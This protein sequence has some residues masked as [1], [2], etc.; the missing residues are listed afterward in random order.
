MG[1]LHKWPLYPLW[2][3]KAKCI[4]YT[5]PPLSAVSKGAPIR[6][7]SAR[8]TPPLTTVR[9][10]PWLNVIRQSQSPKVALTVSA[11]TK[12]RKGSLLFCAT[13]FRLTIG[14][15]A[16]SFLS[17]SVDACHRKRPSHLTMYRYKIHGQPH[18]NL[19]TVPYLFVSLNKES[20]CN[21]IL[22]YYVCIY[23]I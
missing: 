11:T 17:P 2:Q 10:K 8:I 4:G 6:Q 13:Y 14:S 19:Y 23:R 22:K 20:T 1:I 12:G 21:F 18:V 15:R 5:T 3:E 16:L 9:I 7:I